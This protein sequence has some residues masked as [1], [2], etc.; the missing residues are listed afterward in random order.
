MV[1]SFRQHLLKWRTLLSAITLLCLLWHI[2]L[3]TLVQI[4][5]VPELYTMPSHCQPVVL[6][7]SAYQQNFNMEQHHLSHV[8]HHM[9][10]IQNKFHTK[11]AQEVFAL[12]TQIMKHCPLCTHGLDA[13]ILIPLIALIFVLILRW[14]SRVRCLCHTWTIQL[15][16]PVTFYILPIKHAPPTA[17]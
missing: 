8:H 14:F 5:I 2:F 9:E 16:L 6:E 11:H 10:S 4:G 17:L 12:A 7:H 15:E 3:P 1:L 13:A